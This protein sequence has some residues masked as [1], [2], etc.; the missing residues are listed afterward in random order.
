[1][2]DLPMYLSIKGRKKLTVLKSSNMFSHSKEC[3]IPSC[4][5]Q[6]DK[7]ELVDSHIFSQS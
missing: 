4:I 2:L 7:V 5:A 3:V 1:M 6:G